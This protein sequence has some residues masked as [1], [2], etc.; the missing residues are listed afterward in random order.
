MRTELKQ[1]AILPQNFVPAVYNQIES[2][3]SGNKI[4]H[5]R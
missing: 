2:R 4:G 3:R 5:T 1:M